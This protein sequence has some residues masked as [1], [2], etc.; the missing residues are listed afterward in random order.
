[1]AADVSRRLI[2]LNAWDQTPV[3]KLSNVGKLT[4]TDPHKI[5]ASVE[6]SS[7]SRGCEHIYVGVYNSL[8]LGTQSTTWGSIVLDGSLPAGC[9]LRSKA[10]DLLEHVHVKTRNTTVS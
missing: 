7:G 6:S 1:M 10:W 3:A 4:H 9:S 8:T 5:S 2:G